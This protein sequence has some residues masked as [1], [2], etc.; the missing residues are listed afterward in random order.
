MVL[1]DRQTAVFDVTGFALE[2]GKSLEFKALPNQRGIEL[3]NDTGSSLPFTLSVQSVDGESSPVATNDYVTPLMPTGAVQRLIINDW[4]VASQLRSEIDLA[5]DGIADRVAV[6]VSAEATP[7]KEPPELDIRTVGG[8]IVL[9]WPLTTH[10]YYVE[11]GTN[12]GANQNWITLNVVPVVVGGRNEVTLNSLQ[13][14]ALFRL[15]Q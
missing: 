10:A 1:G 14:Q 15:H 9:S 11:R 8:Q 2:G 7:I 3:R 4:P 13:T 5:R 6:F 12:L